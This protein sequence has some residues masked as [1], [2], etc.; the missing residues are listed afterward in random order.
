MEKDK[1]IVHKCPSFKRDSTDYSS[2]LDCL[3]CRRLYNK[4]CPYEDT[5]RKKDRAPHNGAPPDERTD[6]HLKDT[7]APNDNKMV[8]KI[9]IFLMAIYLPIPGQPWRPPVLFGMMPRY[10]LACAHSVRSTSPQ[11]QASLQDQ[12]T[13]CGYRDGPRPHIF[14]CLGA[15][16]HI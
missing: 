12:S 7:P 13:V 8:N 15:F 6:H 3:N 11:F 14:L 1:D 4:T 9:I 5:G 16:A 10:I 2:L